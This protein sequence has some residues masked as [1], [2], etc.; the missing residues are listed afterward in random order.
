VP[1]FF[2]TDSTVV[3]PTH[4]RHR[5]LKR[6]INFYA[7]QK[8]KIFVFVVDSSDDD[9][10]IKNRL[11]FESLKKD[12]P[13]FKCEY[14]HTSQHFKPEIKPMVHDKVLWALDRVTTRYV[15]MCA[16]DDFIIPA[17]IEKCS[18]FLSSN[19]DYGCARGR[20]Y[21]FVTDKKRQF[22]LLPALHYD[23]IESNNAC[24]RAWLAARYYQQTFYGLFRIDVLKKVQAS[25]S[26]R[27]IKQP[28]WADELA[29]ST[30][31]AAMGKIKRINDPYEYREL[32]D[33]NFGHK[34]AR[35]PEMTFEDTHRSFISDYTTSLT[36]LLLSS[37]PKLSLEDAKRTSVSSLIAF[38]KWYYDVR[39]RDSHNRPVGKTTLETRSFIRKLIDRTV[40]LFVSLDSAIQR[41]KAMSFKETR[42]VLKA[43]LNTKM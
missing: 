1:D 16:D 30:Y 4:N 36:S 21:D 18:T 33:E 31:T 12:N 42:D 39:Y 41:K 32:H 37:D 19:P 27:F 38:S 29:M 22:K 8:T 26:E 15:A 25:M 7:N 40:S 34:V 17:A 10:A 9:N 24:E 28:S 11:F 43:V 35:W 23:S 14:N 5:Y 6:L 13:N 20:I 2:T 3:I